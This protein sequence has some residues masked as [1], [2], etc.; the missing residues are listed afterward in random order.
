MLFWQRYLIKYV[1]LIV[2]DE[3]KNGLCV[4]VIAYFMFFS[5]HIDYSDQ[6]TDMEFLKGSKC[7]V[8][9]YQA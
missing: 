1:V 6:V 5:A 7:V 4:C 2:R 8:Y 3:P 9:I